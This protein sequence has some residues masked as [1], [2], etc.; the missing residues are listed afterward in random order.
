MTFAVSAW[1]AY[2]QWRHDDAVSGWVVA[3]GGIA[4]LY[5]PLMPIHLTREIW[6]AINVATAAVFLGHLRVLRQLVDRSEAGQRR[7]AHRREGRLGLSPLSLSRRLLR[8]G[9]RRADSHD[10]ID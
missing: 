6:S 8:R 3:F 1:I 2:E 10:E 9:V 7:V 4:F 5:N